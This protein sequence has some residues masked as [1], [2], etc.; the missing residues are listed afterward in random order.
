[1]LVSSTRGQTLGHLA[2]LQS[3]TFRIALKSEIETLLNHEADPTLDVGMYA[4][5]EL[6]T[7]MSR[8]ENPP[9]NI[10]P[11]SGVRPIVLSVSSRCPFE[12]SSD[13][14]SS[15]RF[16]KAKLPHSAFPDTVDS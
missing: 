14:N 2:N 13:R 6:Q 3:T 5:I 11:R 4:T 10:V 7:D 12:A 1:L 16:V 8:P 9:V 15:L